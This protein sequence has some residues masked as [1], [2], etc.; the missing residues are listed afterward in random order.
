[1]EKV[2]VAKKEGPRR[3]FLYVVGPQKGYSA[4]F[5]PIFE[6][7]MNPGQAEVVL[8]TGGEDINPEL[9]GE[10][11]VHSG[12]VNPER[13]NYEVN[14]FKIFKREKIPMIG[15]CRGAQLLTA[16]NG[17][18]LYQHVNGHA[19]GR[20]HEI[21]T[22][23]GRRYPMTS[24]H[25][26]MMRPAGEYKIIAWTGNLS[27][28]YLTGDDGDHNVEPEREIDPEIVWY[29]GIRALCIQGHPEMMET[30]CPTND[31]VRELAEKYIIS[32]CC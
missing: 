15:I 20:R 21:L 24:L 2:K 26:Q 17:G 13:D 3:P 31:Y 8:F 5:K 23:D 11:N 25:H 28:V 9:Y 29:P 19:I 7:T 30:D 18:K 1:M 14:A 10:K 4:P 32:S 22:D 6:L 12:W 27:N 16:L